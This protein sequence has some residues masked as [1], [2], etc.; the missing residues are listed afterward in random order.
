MRKLLLFLFVLV[1]ISFT[2]GQLNEGFEGTTFPPTGWSVINLGDA[3]T[4]VRATA[5]MRTGVA[6]A[7]IM[8]STAAH[9][10]YLITPQLAPTAGNFTYSFWAQ[11]YLGASYP[12]Q[13]NVLLST[14]GNAAA[15]FTVTLAS[16]ITAPAAYAQFSYNLSAY[17]GQNVYVAIQAISADMYYLTIDDVLGPPMTPTAPPTAQPTALILTPAVSSVAG[18]FTAASPVPNGGY[19][20]VRSTSS[21]L[22][23]N[24]VN[25][26]SYVAGAALG[27]GVVVSSANSTIFTATGLAPAT[28]YY[29]FVFS[30]NT[31]GAGTA[32][33]TTSPLINSTTTGAAIPICGT[34]TVGAT[35]C[36]Y[37]NLTAAMTALSSSIMTC[38]VTLLLN[39][40]YTS[41]TETW[42]I[43]VPVTLGSSTTNTLTIKPNVGVTATISGSLTSALFKVYNSN[44]IIDGSN[45]VGGTTR[46]LT[47][48][49]TS[50]TTPQVFVIGSTGTTPITNCTLKNTIIINGVN[51][52]SAM[53][54]SDGPAPGTA[55]YFN[56]ITIQNIDL[57]KAYIGLYCIAV[58]TPGNGSGLL[59]TGNNINTA[60]A[61]S[62]RLCAVY[63]Q[64]V[65]GATVSN[66]NI[67]NIANTLDAAN[68]SGIWFATATI[69]S[70]ISGNTIGPMSGT[71]GGPRAMA[72]S[73]GVTG[74]NLT[75][76][77]NTITNIS[78]TTTYNA[79]GIY[80]FSTTAGIT[81]SKN[82]I[83]NIKNTNASGYMATAMYL[84]STAAV[85]ANCT[86]VNNAV[87]DI[88]GYGYSSYAW[89][90]L[91]ILIYSGFGYNLYFNTVYMNTE[92]TSITGMPSALFIYSSV[93][94][95]GAIDLRNNIFST[96]QMIGTNRYAIYCLA[97][98]TVFSNMDYNDYYSAGPNLG[99]I[100]VDRVNLAAIQ[101]GFGGNVNSQNI[102][103][104]FVG[105]DLHPTNVALRNKG[106]TIAGV[107][108]DIAGAFRTN[109]PDVGAYQFSP[110]Q[111]VITAAA[112]NLTTT[113]ATLT[114]SINAS[115]LVVL[116]GFEYGLTTGYGTPAA[117]TLPVT[118]TGNTS[119]PISVDIS[120]LLVNN[121]Y[122]YRAIGTSGSLVIYGS[123]MT[124]STA[125]PPVITT[126]AAAPVGAIFA[127][128]NGSV[129]PINASTVVSFEY[130]LS[131][132][133]YSSTATVAGPFTG[134]TVQTFNAAISGLT[135]N[136]TYHFRAKAVNAV[137]T[138][139]GNDMTFFTTCVVPPAPGA[140]SGS[141]AVC[142]T[143][144]GYVYSV[145]PVAYAF[146]YNWTFPAGFNITSYPNSNS[147]TVDVTN[148]AVSGTITVRAQSDC[149]AISPPASIAVTVNALPLPT[150]TGTTSVCQY[151]SY[152]Y[153]TQPGMTSYVWTAAPGG[154]ITTTAN[155]NVVSITWA[156]SGAKTVGVIYTNPA[157]G[158]TATTP[159]TLAV[160]VNAAPTPSILGINS[161]C[162]NSGYYNYT[163]LGGQSSYIWTISSG[164]VINNGQGTAQIEVVWNTP[165]AQ[166]VT[167]NYANG[168]GCFAQTPVTF[169]VTVAGL[170]EAAG[171]ISGSSEVCAGSSGIAYS[172]PAITNAQT[173][174]WSVPAGATIVSGQ[175][176]NAITVNFATNASP[177]NITVYGNSICGNGT[178]SPAFPIVITQ[179]PGAASTITGTAS[180]C[181][182]T[183]GVAYSVPA[184][185]G[186][187]GYNWTLPA[188]AT[189]A[190]GPNT[191]NI[192]VDFAMGASSGA[193]SVNGTN[194]CGNGAAS[195]NFNVTVV[196]KPAAPVITVVGN[197]LSSN[198]TDGNQWFYNGAAITNGTA[199]TQFAQY[200][201]LYTD[202]VTVNGCTSDISNSIY[203]AA[204]GIADPQ[205]SNI[206]I[207]PVPN[208]GL[209]KA[210]FD[211]PGEEI[212]TILVYNQLGEKIYESKDNLV[213]GLFEKN[214][215]LRPTPNGIYSVVFQSV[216]QKIVKKIVVNK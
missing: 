84:A 173:Y 153:T 138:F 144:T 184:I 196:P 21:T 9:N 103:P 212:F 28:L 74:A 100:G 11:S 41:A 165:G 64:G 113:S 54:V 192:T 22:S 208:N 19:L 6:C 214:I 120:G 88:A 15:N 122:H 215:D 166:F 26:T 213:K 24:P 53:M 174:V 70:T 108:T 129:N 27:G 124:F 135:I 201:G 186:A 157:T 81:I 147:V 23:S 65:D 150:V 10:D 123:D 55:G 90:G 189:I 143:N 163:T 36:D 117:G 134:N 34:K 46:N 107:T 179:V 98:N 94:A 137:G 175:L 152:N 119:I 60:G 203:V 181:E 56:N 87:W 16:N 48:T 42:P 168:N 115:N 85:S 69:N 57:Q 139:Y 72:I 178:I 5:N 63:V 199:Q 96:T 1:T 155:P 159:G 68:I 149:G 171:T 109:P 59:I 20:V 170:P 156:T 206:V 131:A 169:N 76:T 118:I 112:T 97:A 7:S 160:T 158:C 78:T 126:V 128:L 8:Y 31:G 33:L 38:P 32:Y 210:S 209:F 40:T 125:I 13:F 110:N 25:G 204:T 71:A 146:V 58:A 194:F 195:A 106:L 193:I 43:I 93:T 30:Y 114:G 111:T 148:A 176:T 142:K 14:T 39:A 45:T 121:T 101:T 79:I 136:T 198:Y 167:V 182:G 105:V 162:V 145:A 190:S 66:N 95:V 141:V 102:N 83:S 61:N 205:A 44:T 37:V 191:A 211:Y 200:S 161:M 17:I 207:S 91:G 86:V 2:Y 132:T 177:G 130:G 164:G 52:S 73:S 202:I 12:E 82:M 183:T 18:T 104:T 188:G 154:V 67:G 80:F 50:A 197:I 3:N 127:T 116:S 49:N 133:P 92:Q 77:G 29:F 35:G 140:I 180:L 187:T 99:Y 89:N 172:S 216:D 47:I 62:I 151:A 51:T 4:W 75:V 185:T